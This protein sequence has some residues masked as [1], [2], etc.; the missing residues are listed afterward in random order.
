MK[1]PANTFFFPVETEF[2][3][4]GL[5]YREAP[6]VLLQSLLPVKSI[7]D[8]ENAVGDAAL[9]A[10]PP[11]RAVEIGRDLESYFKGARA[12]P[13]WDVMSMEGLTKLQRRV[14]EETAKIPY[15]QVRSYKEIAVASGRTNA[16]RFVGAVMARNPFPVF[17][18]CHRV[19]RSDGSLGGFG[20]GL[21]LKS[22]MLSLEGAMK[23]L[24]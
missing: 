13:P 15:G 17:I 11:R 19:V 24:A 3:C 14:L 22:R 8:L 18:P 16:C 12:A 6:F 21:D 1:S 5:I 7:K 20:G 4:G 2:G 9:S 10:R 23:F